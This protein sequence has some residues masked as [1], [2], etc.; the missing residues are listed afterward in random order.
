MIILP[1]FKILLPFEGGV[2]SVSP[3]ETGDEVVLTFK[4]FYPSVFKSY[5]I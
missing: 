2:D 3:K 4:I 1:A 5:Q